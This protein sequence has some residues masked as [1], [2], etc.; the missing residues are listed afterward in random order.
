MIPEKEAAGIRDNRT[1][2]PRK[3]AIEDRDIVG[4]VASDP[5]FPVRQRKPLAAPRAFDR[6]DPEPGRSG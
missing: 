6:L 3:G 5:H 1:V 4:R 2:M